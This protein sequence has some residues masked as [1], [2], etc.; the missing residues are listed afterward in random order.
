MQLLHITALLATLVLGAFGYPADLDALAPGYNNDKTSFDVIPYPGAEKITLHGTFQEV[1][2]QVLEI[3]PNYESDWDNDSR[4]RSEA[5]LEHRAEKP[6]LLSCEDA[7]AMADADQIRIGIKYIRNEWTLPPGL[8][9]KTCHTVSCSHNSAIRWCN[10]RNTLRVLPSWNNI[11]DAATV[12]V[13]WCTNKRANGYTGTK[14]RLGHWDEW[15]VFVDRG[16]C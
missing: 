9:A 3:N 12:I 16:K 7:W 14:G 8:A 13:K 1:Y 15:R 11:A 5:V 6:P 2:A 10:D 4:N